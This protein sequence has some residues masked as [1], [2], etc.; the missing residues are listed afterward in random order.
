M[1]P[2]SLFLLR[3][4]TET[5]VTFLCHRHKCSSQANCKQKMVIDPLENTVRC[6]IITL[7][8]VSTALHLCNHI[9][10]RIYDASRC[11]SH[12]MVGLDHAASKARKP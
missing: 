2:S 12:S 6:S 9:G 8:R 5:D 7:S 3:I 4:S 10:L 1:A 11:R